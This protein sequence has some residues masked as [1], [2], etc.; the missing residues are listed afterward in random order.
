MQDNELFSI[1]LGED[2]II[3]VLYGYQRRV[4]LK[5]VKS[6]VSQASQLITV[7]HPLIVSGPNI[8][9]LDYDAGK[10]QASQEPAEIFSAVAVITRTRLEQTLGRM[11]M[12]IHKSNYPVRLFTTE[13]EAE[14]WLQIYLPSESAQSKPTPLIYA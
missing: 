6:A 14:K 7:K 1:T 13:A 8:I 3:R 2:Q 9:Y 5:L 10:Y 11:F 12:R 4:T